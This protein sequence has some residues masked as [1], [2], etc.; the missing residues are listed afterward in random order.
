[1]STWNGSTTGL[2]PSE[3]QSA[4]T[5]AIAAADLP[6]TAE[7]ET[8]AETGAA[9]AIVAADLPDT[10][11]VQ[12]A[13]QQ[14]AGD[15]IAAANLPSDADVQAACEAALVSEAGGSIP[16]VAQIQTGLATAANLATLQTSVNALPSDA[17][18]QTAASAAITA[19]AGGAI[20]SVAQILAP[21]DTGNT[22][23]SVLVA[24]ALQAMF[25]ATT[26]NEDLGVTVQFG[27]T[28]SAVGAATATLTTTPSDPTKFVD[29]L[30]VIISVTGATTVGIGVS[31]GG[32]GEILQHPFTAAGTV[33][34]KADQF[35]FNGYGPFK[36]IYNDS[37]TVTGSAGGVTV[38]ATP[39]YRTN[40]V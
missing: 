25:S 36:R 13:A 35:V 30:G 6:T 24:S 10:A 34:L 26:E 2:T 22:P 18:V 31:S 16:S 11:E 40:E 17:D 29:L 4:C 1:M 32:T 39:W 28:A 7:V 15:A 12:A 8:A 27:A 9:A 3:V 38:H 23:L 5:A 20:P 37:F 33:Y 14:G 21:L 19:A